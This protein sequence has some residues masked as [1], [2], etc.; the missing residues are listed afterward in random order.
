MEALSNTRLSIK[1]TESPPSTLLVLPAS[2]DLRYLNRT[3]S[4]LTICGFSK[5]KTTT[6]SYV[7]IESLITKPILSPL[8]LELFDL[9]LFSCFVKFTCIKLNFNNKIIAHTFV[10]KYYY[11]LS[12]IVTF[13]YLRIKS[14][15]LKSTY[16]NKN[17]IF[18]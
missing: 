2:H 16:L 13:I 8:T 3:S 18:V 17:S 5:K 7:S 10:K 9:F 12:F 1:G 15:K 4:E 11:L 14:C 6:L